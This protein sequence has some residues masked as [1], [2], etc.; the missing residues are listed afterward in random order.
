[1]KFL[2]SIIYG[3]ISG[4]SEFLPI[5]SSAHQ[6]LIGSVLGS[7]SADPVRNLFVHIAVLLALW[8]GTEK[9]R[10]RIRAAQRNQSRR[11]KEAGSKAAAEYRLLRA[12][13]IPFLIAFFLLRYILPSNVSLL[14]ISLF[15]LLNGI[16]IFLPDRM[17]QGNKN[18]KVMTKFDGA[19][20]GISGALCALPGFSRVG[21]M[22]SVAAM[23]GAERKASVNWALLLSIP[24][25]VGWVILDF[26]AL[27]SGSGVPF[28]SNLLYYFI[29]A[30][31][32]FLGTRASIYVLRRH[33]RSVGCFDD[34]VKPKPMQSG[35]DLAEIGIDE[36]TG[37]RRSQDRADLVFPGLIFQNFDHIQDV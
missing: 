21:V 29:S 35:D 30:L 17:L 9:A 11:R 12:A 6:R 13:T 36:L 27:L 20:I 33:I 37:D 19:L 7:D 4:F 18:A 24:A 14:L 25:L 8:L 16:V 10:N 26:L 23:R 3:F 32:A 2:E 34:H 15:L 1:M 31:F 28:W 22:Y 5:S